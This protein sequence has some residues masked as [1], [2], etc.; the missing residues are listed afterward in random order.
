MSF[1]KKKKKKKKND[2]KDSCLKLNLQKLQDGR[3]YN[4]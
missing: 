3:K 4:I 2:V 1:G